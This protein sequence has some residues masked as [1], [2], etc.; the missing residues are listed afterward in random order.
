MAVYVDSMFD[1]GKRIGRAGPRWAHLL[2]DTPDELHAFAGRLGLQRS[3]FQG[4][5][6]D[7]GTERI[8][9]LALSLGAIH[10]SGREWMATVTRIRRVFRAGSHTHA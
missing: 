3:W 10:Q 4:D 9:D 5:H 7:I 1:W 6:Y 8:Y 2:A